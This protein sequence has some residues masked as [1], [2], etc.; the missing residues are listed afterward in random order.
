MFAFQARNSASVARMSA[1]IC[2]LAGPACRYA[3]AGYACYLVYPARNTL[4]VADYVDT[5][6][7]GNN[8]NWVKGAPGV[9]SNLSIENI[10]ED[11]GGF[12]KLVAKLHE[13]GDVRVERDATL[14]GRSGAPRQIDVLLRHKQGLYEHLVVVECKYW[15]RNVERSDV[16][17]LVR[18]VHEVG[19]SRGVIFSSKGFQ[20]GAITQAEHD[21]IDLFTVRE[22]TDREWGAPGRHVSLFLHVVSL[23]PGPVTIHEAYAHAHCAP[24]ANKIDS[25]IGEGGPRPPTHTPIETESGKDKTLEEMLTRLAREAG[26][27]V[28]SPKLASFSGSLRGQIFYRVNVDIVPTKDIKVYIH[29]GLLF[30]RK[31]SF[32]LGLRIDQSH[33]AVDRAK[34]FVFALAIENCVNRQVFGAARRLGESITELAPLIDVVPD[35]NGEAIQNNSI[36]SVWLLPMFPF[37]DFA[38]MKVGEGRFVSVAE[39]PSVA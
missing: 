5:I 16:D 17:S 32:H 2:G 27:E 4:L 1:A 10:V 34:S 28:Y 7:I 19:A 11:W 6:C 20:S 22:P 12:E 24:T 3:H 33:I 23:A 13:T 8:L 30:I 25:V 26:K 21:K 39:G 37:D 18:T 36:I 31:M 35:R 15:N 9:V 14:I 38:D 29:D